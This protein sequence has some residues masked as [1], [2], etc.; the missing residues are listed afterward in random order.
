MNLYYENHL[1]KRIHFYRSPYIL[2]N[3][4]F[5]DW[6]L[7]FT[8]VNNKT[9][10]YV[11][12][13]SEADF[14]VRLMPLAK[15]QNLRE[16]MFAELYDEMVEVFSADASEPG[17]LWTDGG[18]YLSCRVISSKKSKWNI[19]RDV[20]V[21]CRISVDSP[22][23]KRSE[24]EQISFSADTEYKYLDYPYGYAYDYKGTLTGYTEI[25][26]DGTEN[27]DFVMTVYGPAVNPKVIVNGIEVG[28]NVVI[29]EA[30]QL[31]IS[32]SAQTVAVLSGSAQKNAF[33]KR[34]K[35]TQ[36]MFTKLPPGTVTIMWSGLF[37][38]DLE[39]IR[40]RREPSW[41]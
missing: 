4:S 32:T 13:P 6:L 25:A 2:T 26:N 37:K 33:N 18:E 14:T 16:A 10:G 41:T 15:T 28:A 5:F 8:T 23:W 22:T 31:V 34:F 17:K 24:T 20:T 1:G 30:E 11:F 39:I 27:S 29:G 19:P 7:S 38:F 21:V 3:H 40:E 35:G 36:S 12:K 9:S